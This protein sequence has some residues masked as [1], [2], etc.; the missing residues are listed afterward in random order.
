ML[1]Q[2][3][4]SSKRVTTMSCSN[5][6]HIIPHCNLNPLKTGHFVAF[7][8]AWVIVHLVFQLIKVC[9]GFGLVAMQFTINYLP[10]PALNR[11]AVIRWFCFFC[12]PYRIRDILGMSKMKDCGKAPVYHAFIINHHELDGIVG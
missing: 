12:L 6:I 8:L 5:K 4:F 3:M 10:N 2:L 1:C 7:A 11:S 9:N